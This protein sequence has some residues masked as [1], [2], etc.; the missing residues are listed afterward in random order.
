MGVG[1]TA[2]S[3]ASR[4]A[5]EGRSPARTAQLA[6]SAHMA[7]RP[8]VIGTN[9]GRKGTKTAAGALSALPRGAA[10]RRTAP[11]S[12]AR[13]PAAPASPSAD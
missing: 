13:C 10:A 1:G 9:A 12:P 3:P 11:F 6:A 5:R 8:E 4:Q 7:A 2:E